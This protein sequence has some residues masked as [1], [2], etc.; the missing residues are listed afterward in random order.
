M[1]DTEHEQMNKLAIIL[2]SQL[3]CSLLLVAGC[4]CGAPVVRAEAPNTEPPPTQPPPSTPTSGLDARPANGTCVAWPRPSVG[5][6]ISLSRFTA[7]S[8]ALPIG[9]LQAP[10]DSARWYVVEQG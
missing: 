5:S 2:G 9:L 8:F 10:N 7:L 3:A 4:D 6:D 1:R